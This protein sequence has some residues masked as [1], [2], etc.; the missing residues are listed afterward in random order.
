M[1]KLTLLLFDLDATLV[2]TGGI[3]MVA[4]NQAFEETIGWPNALNEI[5][6]AGRTDTSIAHELSNKHRDHDMSAEELISVFVRYLELLEVKIKTAENYRV[7]PGIQEF[8]EK[9]EAHPDF[10][11]GLGTGNLEGG[12][13]IKLERADLNRFFPFGGFGSDAVLRPDVLRIGI[14]RG[15]AHLE[16]P[17]PRDQVVIIGDTHLD[18][19]AGKQLGTKTIG[20][21]T[22]P[23]SVEQLAEHQPD[24]AIQDFSDTASL[25]K[26]FKF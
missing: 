2:R 4:M 13:H 3:G 15:E 7:L 12:A 16:C 5:S 17:I 23:Y 9:A 6:P 10:A 1:S 20:V 11:L 18:I 8:L 22:G 25:D 24:L 14:E 19:A 26:F 21:A